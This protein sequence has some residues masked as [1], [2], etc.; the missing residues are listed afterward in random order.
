MGTTCVWSFLQ[1]IGEAKDLI[2]SYGDNIPGVI[3]EA[4]KVEGLSK[5]TP[6]GVKDG[7]LVIIL[8]FLAG[9]RWCSEGDEGV[10]P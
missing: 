2:N 1:A 4:L 5:V 6:L 3:V 9:A 10:C 8:T 7:R